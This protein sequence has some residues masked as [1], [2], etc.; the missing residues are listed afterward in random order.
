MAKSKIEWTE[1]SWNPVTGCSKISLGCE[2]CYAER[3][4]KRLQA[5]GQQNYKNGFKVTCHL[6]VLEYPL[7]WKKPRIIFVNSMSDLFHEDVP[8]EFVQDIFKVMNRAHWHTFQILTKRPERMLIFADKL[9]W[10][11]NIWMGVT[12]ESYKYKDRINILRE[13]P[14]IIK[15][16]SAEPLIEPLGKLDLTN[17]NWMIVG[18]ESGIGARPMSSSWVEEVKVQCE[19]FQIPFFFKQWGGTNKKKTG[20]ILNGKIYNE[21]PKIAFA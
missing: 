9:N 7:K 3:M 12:I 18:G 16:I 10:T 4:A 14:A 15:F 8:F 13:I 1:S 19:K 17:I 20:R 2:N 11:P 5:M 6:K 21:M